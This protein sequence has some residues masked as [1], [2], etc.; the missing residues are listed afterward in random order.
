MFYNPVFPA[1]AHFFGAHKKKASQASTH[2]QLKLCSSLG[3]LEDL[4][5]KSIPNHLL[6]PTDSGDH[7]RS[8]IFNLSVI[9]W[10]FLAQVLS[11]ATSCREIVRRVQA[12]HVAICPLFTFSIQTVAYCKA[13]AKI[14]EK[15][16][17]A[18][19]NHLV[20][21]C[22]RHTPSS[23]LWLGRRVKI[24]DGTTISM[25]DTAKNQE[26]YPQPSSQSPG[27]G[28][29][30]MN[31]VGIF[32]LASGALLNFAKDTIHVHESLL[33]RR[34]WAFLDKGDIILADRG[35]C[36]YCAIAS[37]RDLGVDCVIRLNQNRKTDMRYGKRI[38]KNDRLQIWQKPIKKP[39]GLSK[40]E[41]AQAPET[42]TVRVVKIN[43]NVKGFRTSH[44]LILTTLLD[45]KAF[46][47]E[48]L[49]ELYFARW[50]IE[51]R[52][53]EI[54]SIC[55]MDILK[56]LS[57]DMILRELLMHTIA[58]NVV[59]SLMQKAAN[60][61]NV[62][63]GRISFKGTLD[64]VRHWAPLINN[65]KSTPSKQKKL[66]SKMLELIAKDLVPERPNRIEPRAIKRRPKSYP[67]LTQPR[68]QMSTQSH[69]N[70][71]K[72]KSANNAKN[73]LS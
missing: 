17:S 39:K 67:R 43:V 27:C 30:L 50:S 54:K 45:P 19:A 72:S 3:E 29:P 52:F 44:C 51:L 46:K 28:F 73:P 7:S 6:Q 1:L 11:P 66:I 15:T 38:G 12:W 22:E 24:V 40:E 68:K 61:Y 18:I 62:P 65:A 63:L 48:N 21:H 26:A 58:Y 4:C 70:H 34:L 41:F 25:P 32:S 35:F 57:P 60:E 55:G 5:G 20:Q 23:A 56:C 14:P 10:A 2:E 33:F 8:R 49:G 59:R 47:I 69:N 13:R 64:T 37:L 42:L 71:S 36:S 16:L 53:R 9:F 31:I